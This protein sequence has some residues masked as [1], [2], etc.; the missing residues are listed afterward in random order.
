MKQNIP[1]W[2]TKILKGIYVIIWTA[3]VF[4]SLYYV[5]LDDLYRYRGTDPQPE[6]SNED[7][8][9]GQSTEMSRTLFH[10]N[11]EWGKEV[12][13][14]IKQDKIFIPFFI[15]IIMMFFDIL[16]SYI[17][18]TRRLDDKDVF[19]LIGGIIALFLGCLL[20]GL[21]KTLGTQCLIIISMFFVLGI[22]KAFRTPARACVDILPSH[23]WKRIDQKRKE[24]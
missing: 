1:C 13:S 21:T 4:F 20:I 3:L 9:N 15:A 10:A 18:D 8:Q 12:S 24:E 5:D 23:D 11:F 2:A 14:E 6:A 16:Y 17:L 19:S 7:P 22:M